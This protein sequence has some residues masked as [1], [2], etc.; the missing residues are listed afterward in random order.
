MYTFKSG[1]RNN[2]QDCSCYIEKRTNLLVVE[3][4]NESEEWSRYIRLTGQQV[5]RIKEMFF[6][7]PFYSS[8]KPSN[9]FTLEGDVITMCCRAENQ[10]IRLTIEEMGHVFQ[11]YDRHKERIA[12][13]DVQFK[14]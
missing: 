1:K 11:Y 5:K 12:R 2:V 3:Q 4:K 8:T 7:G 9:Y 6:K 13:F 14:K 10:V